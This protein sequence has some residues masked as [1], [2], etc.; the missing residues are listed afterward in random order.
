MRINQHVKPTL[1]IK[2]HVIKLQYPKR[3]CRLVGAE[4]PRRCLPSSRDGERGRQTTCPYTG[5]LVAAV[6]EAL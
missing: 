3:L 1:E 2:G 4:S 5:K 6:S